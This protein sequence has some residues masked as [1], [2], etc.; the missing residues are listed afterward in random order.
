M[1]AIISDAS[2]A[3]SLIT[4]YLRASSVPRVNAGC[5]MK[6]N[7][8]GKNRSSL[9]LFL[10]L[11]Q[12]III[13]FQNL[14]FSTATRAS[15]FAAGNAAPLQISPVGFTILIRDSHRDESARIR[16][17]YPDHIA[18]H[19]GPRCAFGPPTSLQLVSRISSSPT[20]SSLFLSFSLSFPVLFPFFFPLLLPLFFCSSIP[21]LSL[22]GEVISG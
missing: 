14:L 5:S 2:Q 1:H 12:K 17:M 6:I 22:N 10:L 13:I 16:A 20:L 19:Y 15:H 18:F 4:F 9:I 8:G 11:L 3:R 7:D 21:L